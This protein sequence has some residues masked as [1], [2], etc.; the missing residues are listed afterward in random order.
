LWRFSDSW[1]LLYLWIDIAL[2]PAFVFERLSPRRIE[3]R[4]CGMNTDSGRSVEP[5]AEMSET[6]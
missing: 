4:I 3:K 1:E 6:S 2:S 5:F